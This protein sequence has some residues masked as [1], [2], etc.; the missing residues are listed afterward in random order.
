MGERTQ[1]SQ[2][3]I[4][5][6]QTRELLIET[7]METYGRYGI[8]AV[9]TADIA[10]AA[11]VSH[12]TVFAHFGTQ[13]TLLDTV[14]EAFGMRISRR[15]HEL[16]ASRRSLRDVLSAHI[17]G[18]VEY[19]SFYTRLVTERRLLPQSARHTLTAIQSAISFHIGQ[20][21]M[22]EMEAGRIG[23]YPIHLLFNTWVGLIHHYIANS[24]L[25]VAEGSVLTRYG[26]ELLDHY[27]RLI[28]RRAENIERI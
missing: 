14:I 17:Q 23:D 12:G 9:T 27:M 2:R 4:Q 10:K 28:S 7:A 21:A 6:E 13:E 19:E 25:F 3:Q 5:K 20:A 24:D 11:G 15:L 16:A 1:K 8:L 26:T 18:L 22:A